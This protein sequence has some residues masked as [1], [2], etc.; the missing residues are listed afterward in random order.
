[1]SRALRRSAR[2]SRWAAVRSSTERLLYP[3]D[4]RDA[5]LRALPPHHPLLA[6]SAEAVQPVVQRAALGKDEPSVPAPPRVPL[7]GGPHHARHGRRRPARRRE[8]MLDVYADFCENC[9][10]HASHRAAQKT[11]KEKFDG[12][13]ATYTIECMMHD[14]KALQA[15]T[16]HLLSATALPR[17][18]AFLLHGQEQPAAST[19]FQTSWGVSTRHDRRHH[20]DP[21]RQQRPR[22]AAEDRADADRHH[23]D[24]HAQGGRAREGTRRAPRRCARPAFA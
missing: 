18:S 23:P 19:R 1:M 16:S 3:P 13:E 5:V 2:G 14:R 22:P 6:R 20:H 9:A 11:D 15:G 8:R 12:A 17:R 24:R 10:G 7:A 21:R 4:V